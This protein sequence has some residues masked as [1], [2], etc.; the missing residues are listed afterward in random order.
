[1]KPTNYGI[2]LKREDQE[3]THDEWVFGASSPDCIYAVPLSEREKFLPTGE[4]QNIGDEK[5]DCVSRGYHNVLE[6][7]FTYALQTGKIKPENAQWLKDNGYVK[8]NKIEF[9]DVFTAILSGTTRDGNSMKAPAESIRKNGLVP[10]SKLVQLRSWEDNYDTKRI[11]TELKNLGQEFLKRWAI[12]YEQVYLSDLESLLKR[13]CANLAGYAWPKPKNGVYPKTKGN[14][15]HAFMAFLPLTYIFDN[16]LEGKDDW[17]KLLASDYI[18]YEYGYRPFVREEKTASEYRSLLVKAVQFLKEIIEALNPPKAYDQDPKTLPM[19]Q[20]TLKEQLL[21]L[22]KESVGTNVRSGTAPKDLGC[23]DALSS[24]LGKIMDFPNEISTVQLNK[25]LSTDKRFKRTLDLNKG[26]IIMSYTVGD[27]TGHCGVII[28]DEK[29][30][31]NTSKTGLWEQNYTVSTWVD[32]FRKKQGLQVL[33]Y[34]FK[35]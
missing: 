23:A 34:T 2:D 18:F 32:Y 27:K 8:D 15:N 33:V 19:N 5:M 14:I 26:N 30:C 25:L 16:Y 11:T 35:E 28:E 29:I 31:S 9:S 17:I 7:K 4:L 22:A 10:K 20:E 21:K 12:N 24:L 6:T 13:D 1:M 3:L